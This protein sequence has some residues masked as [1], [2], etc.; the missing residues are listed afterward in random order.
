MKS[1]LRTRPRATDGT[2]D[3]FRGALVGVAVGDAL[4]APFEGYPGVVDDGRLASH[5]DGSSP[6]RFTDDT[7]LTVATAESLLFKGALDAGHLLACFAATY[8]RDP[9]RGYGASTASI[10]ARAPDGDRWRPLAAGQFGGEGS[11]GNGA[12]MR[13]A[14]LAI[15]AGGDPVRASELARRAA[16]PTHT[17]PIGVEGAAVQAAAV[18]LALRGTDPAAMPRRLVEVTRE[19]HLLAGLRTVAELPADAAP[20]TVAAAT[21]TGVVASDAVPA[22][23]AAFVRNGGAFE[24]TTRFAIALGGDT[25]TIA[26]MAGALAGAAGGLASVPSVWVGRCEGTQRMVELADRFHLRRGV[27][28]A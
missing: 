13:V 10:L 17:H 11:F 26:S 14:P 6:L 19:P 20:A 15:F 18:A 16:Q 27:D 1:D 7:A 9:S 12:A 5:L 8:A 28:P 24:P 23:L 2:C 4:G 3:R 22:A 25:D 21:G